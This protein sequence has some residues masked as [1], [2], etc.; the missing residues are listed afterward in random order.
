MCKVNNNYLLVILFFT[1]SWIVLSEYSLLISYRTIEGFKG[2]WFVDTSK[3][4]REKA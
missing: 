3:H 2:D 4:E 1:E